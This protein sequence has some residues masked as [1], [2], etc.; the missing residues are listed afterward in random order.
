MHTDGYANPDDH[1]DD[2]T[3]A[4]L[5]VIDDET[6]DAGAGHLFAVEDLIRQRLTLGTAEYLRNTPLQ[7]GDRVYLLVTAA[8][9]GHGEKTD[10]EGVYYPAWLDCDA[11]EI[12]EGEAAALLQHRLE[13][14]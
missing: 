12:S 14:R 9:T 6:S 2:E 13:E 7:R 10:S 11:R 3:P 4:E 1:D 5:A 8:T